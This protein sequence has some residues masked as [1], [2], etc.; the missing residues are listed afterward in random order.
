MHAPVHVWHSE[1][2][3]LGGIASLL[4]LWVLGIELRSSAL[5]ASPYPLSHRP[6][7]PVSL[8]NTVG[9]VLS[10]V[11]VQGFLVFIYFFRNSSVVNPWEIIGESSEGAGDL[12]MWAIRNSDV[13]TAA[14]LLC[15]GPRV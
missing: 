6:G 14:F 8:W 2:D 11:N 15:G 4:P 13:V 5:V 12:A 1:E 3:L 10:V 9:T 7:P